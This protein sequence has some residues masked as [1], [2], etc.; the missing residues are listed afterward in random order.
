M[1][2]NFN[3]VLMLRC[4][5]AGLRGLPDAGRALEPKVIRAFDVRRSLRFAADSACPRNTVKVSPHSSCTISPL[6][7]SLTLS[8]P[9]VKPKIKPLPPPRTR[10]CEAFVKQDAGPLTLAHYNGIYLLVEKIKRSKNR[11]DIKKLNSK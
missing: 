7:A 11:V 10:F 1:S 4:F 3:P 6:S 9:L 2:N 8:D 5:F